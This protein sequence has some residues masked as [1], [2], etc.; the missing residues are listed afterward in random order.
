[1]AQPAIR[2]RVQHA[3]AR[4]KGQS[5]GL[6]ISTSADLIQQ[7]ERGFPFRSLQTFA[8]RSSLSIPKIG[9]IIGIPERTLA[10]R[11]SS[12]KLSWEESERLLRLS[13]IFE[14]ALEL[15]EGDP[16]GAIQWLTSTQKALGDQ[17]PLA[18]ARTEVGA[19]EVE[20][21]VGRLE[22]GVFS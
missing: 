4:S 9:S 14:D 7:V 8:E 1:M 22:H 6:K 18:H 16:S 11:R 10:R 3:R 21:L 17:T 13:A 5:L 2:S 15:F 12:G 19:R 20:E